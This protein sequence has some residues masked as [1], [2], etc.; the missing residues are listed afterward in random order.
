MKEDFKPVSEFAISRMSNEEMID[1]Y[2]DLRE[3]IYLKGEKVKGIK[4]RQTIKPIIVKFLKLQRLFTGKKLEILGDESIK[5][6]NRPTIYAI[7]HIG[8]YDLEIV[9]EA[10]KEQAHILCGDPETMYRNLDGF[11]AQLNGAVYVDTDS[12][13]D[14]HVAKETAIK[15]LEQGGNILIYPEGIWNL[16][17]ARPIL[18]LYPGVIEMAYRTNA[19]I[20]PVG[21]EQYDDKFIVNIG[22]NFEVSDYIDSDNYTKEQE[23]EARDA[24]R[25]AMASLKWK[26]W[27]T[28]G[29][30][31]REDFPE[32]Y[33]DDFVNQRLNEWPV[34]DRSTLEK[35]TFKEKGVTSQNEVYQFTKKLIPKKENAFLFR[36]D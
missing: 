33:Y 6:D 5:E 8:R 23:N 19:S 12:K 31:S 16:E 29:E 13:S 30:C 20:V 36:K 17:P 1:Y 27:E 11:M 32:S 2:R 26:I 4:L 18:P 3:Y 7:S 15:V 22:K 9:C 25:D 14:R 35:R 10:I 34:Y 21:I 24:L 28:A